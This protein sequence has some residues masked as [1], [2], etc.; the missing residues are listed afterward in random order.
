MWRIFFREIWVFDLH[1]VSSWYKSNDWSIRLNCQTRYILGNSDERRVHL[2]SFRSSKKEI[3]KYNQHISSVEQC[4]I[5]ILK[6][7]T[8]HTFSN[9]FHSVLALLIELWDF[10]SVKDK[11]S[12]EA[13]SWLIFVCNLKKWR[14]QAMNKQKNFSRHF[15][16]II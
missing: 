12:K 15:F 4:L 14:W 2:E 16:L 6:R 8:I 10:L 11:S 13:Y 7:E 3:N 1:T 5:L 9:Q